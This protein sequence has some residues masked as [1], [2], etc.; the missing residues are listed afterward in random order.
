VAAGKQHRTMMVERIRQRLIQ[1]KHRQPGHIQ[2][3]YSIH[4]WPCPQS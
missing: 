2:T 3:K 4:L 1:Y